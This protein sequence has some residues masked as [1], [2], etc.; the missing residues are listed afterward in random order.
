MSLNE[1]SLENLRACYRQLKKATKTAALLESW[2]KSVYTHSQMFYQLYFRQLKLNFSSRKS[3]WLICSSKAGWVKFFVASLLTD[4]ITDPEL[5]TFQLCFWNWQGK[6]N[7]CLGYDLSKIS[8]VFYIK[9]TNKQK[10]IKQ[11]NKQNKN[12]NKDFSRRYL[13]L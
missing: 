12:T 5:S 8:S 11:T 1:F 4:N 6:H 7:R 3:Q 10:T 2:I 13:A 9:N